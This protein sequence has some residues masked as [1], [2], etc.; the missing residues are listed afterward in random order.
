MAAKSGYTRFFAVAHWAGRLV[1]MEEIWSVLARGVTSS[2]MASAYWKMRDAWE[3][4]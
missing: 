2:T 1:G 4:R 3:C